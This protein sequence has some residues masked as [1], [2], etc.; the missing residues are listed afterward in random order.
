VPVELTVSVD[1]AAPPE[2]VWAAAVDWER[3]SEWVPFTTV[4]GSHGLGGTLVART[5]IGPFGFDDPMSIVTWEPP[6]RCVVR[7]HGR[8]VRG[9]AAFEVQPLGDGGARFVW[10]E[11]LVLPLGVVGE[12]GFLVVRP[13]FLGWLRRSLREFSTRGTWGAPSRGTT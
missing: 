12:L 5:A 2:E 4:S 7:H 8:V 11:W 3:Q 1:V 10:T 9:S 13:F 6:W